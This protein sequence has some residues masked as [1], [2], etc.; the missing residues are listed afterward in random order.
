MYPRE[1]SRDFFGGSPI[2]GSIAPVVPV[3]I[4]SNTLDIRRIYN[5]TVSP[6]KNQG[7][8]SIIYILTS[9]RGVQYT[10]CVDILVRE[11]K[12][13]R[14][15]CGEIEFVEF[16]KL[17]ASDILHIV[18][19]S[20]I[21]NVQIPIVSDDPDLLCY[22]LTRWLMEERSFTL[23]E[24]LN[25]V[26]EITGQGSMEQKYRSSLLDLYDSKWPLPA[27]PL[28]ASVTR[29]A[30]VQKA[31][32]V[33]GID[34]LL[35]ELNPTAVGDDICSSLLKMGIIPKAERPR[36]LT[37]KILTSCTRDILLLPEP[38]GQHCVCIF[39]SDKT[40]LY[41]PKDKLGVVLNKGLGLTGT[42]TESVLLEDGS[43]VITDVYI[44]KNERLTK[45]AFQARNSMMKACM[46]DANRVVKLQPICAP[47]EARALCRR[48]F[49]DWPL[50][51]FSVMHN[52]NRFLWKFT[53][54]EVVTV[55][56]RAPF[57]GNC[58]IG[59]AIK[60]PDMIPVVDFGEFDPKFRCYDGEPVYA[61]V[62]SGTRD[63]GTYV[64]PI[65]EVIGP[66]DIDS[67]VWTYYEFQELYDDGRGILSETEMLDLLIQ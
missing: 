14:E 46:K 43:L 27:A 32:A 20:K 19:R 51:G 3:I 65:G 48:E 57:M 6:W 36:R 13:P 35:A 29:F 12:I 59:N 63:V 44:L 4:M 28:L 37:R 30:A 62:T 52:E 58:M 50:Q 38:E 42:V 41:F 10:P 34:K 39:E 1:V 49:T 53:N 47:E 60:A 24:A 66:A 45:K 22:F 61:R 17:L 67:D 16:K 25:A 7:S 55:F 15:T 26:K 9:K 56:L 64:L 2:F 54:S 23:A 33:Q 8:Q 11:F 31:M 21:R 18:K 40:K 5:S